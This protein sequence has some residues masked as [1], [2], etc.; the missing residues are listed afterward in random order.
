MTMR[1]GVLLLA[2]VIAA[3]ILAGCSAEPDAPIPALW[4]NEDGSS[5]ELDSDGNATL[6]RVPVGSG[7]NCGTDEASIYS[8]PASWVAGDRHG[9]LIETPVG[10]V[11][12]WAD[13]EGFGGHLN[14]S[15]LRVG[16]CGEDSHG[17]FVVN[18]QLNT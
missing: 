14:W 11:P 13:T 7:D 6:Y 8:G 4:D 3:S 15:K 16:I 5:I 2:S 12:V 10:G 17:K 9:Y 1:R 18:Y